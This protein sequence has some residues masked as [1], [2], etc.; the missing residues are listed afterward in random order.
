MWVSLFGS[1]VTDSLCLLPPSCSRTLGA[2]AVIIPDRKQVHHNIRNA[3]DSHD[4]VELHAAIFAASRF[5]A[6]SKSFSVNMCSKISEMIRGFATPLDMKIKLVPIF[7]HMHHDA[8]TAQV[9]GKGREE[10]VGCLDCFVDVVRCSRSSLGRQA[11]LHRD[12]PQ[13]PRRG[14]HLR[15]PA[16]DDLALR[17]H[18]G[19]PARPGLSPAAIPGRRSK[20]GCENQGGEGSQVCL[21][22]LCCCR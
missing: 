6:R 3:L 10:G 18:P 14:L 9:G 15:H 8:Q 11:D 2:I 1:P 20:G 17:A 5:A 21:Q 13:L 22:I 19:G 12:A 4:A 7:Q 16:H